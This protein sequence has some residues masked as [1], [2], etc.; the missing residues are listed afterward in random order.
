MPQKSP[1]SFEKVESAL[2]VI[3]SVEF[4]EELSAKVMKEL[5][6]LENRLEKSTDYEE[7]EALMVKIELMQPQLRQI[8]RR[9]ELEYQNINK[10]CKS[11][12]S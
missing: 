3:K 7:K 11:C 4:L 10:V 6:V 12:L 9:C 5:S 8:V 1:T 2:L